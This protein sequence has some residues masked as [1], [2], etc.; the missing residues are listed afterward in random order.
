[1]ALPGRRPGEPGASPPSA[2]R[3]ACAARGPAPRAGRAT[4]TRPGT[5]PRRTPTRAGRATASPARAA[6][7]LTIPAVNPDARFGGRNPSRS[8]IAAIAFGAPP[9]RRAAPPAGARERTMIADSYIPAQPDGSSARGRRPAGPLHPHGDAIIARVDGQ[10]HTV[11]QQP[12]DLPPVRRR[13]SSGPATARR[14]FPGQPTDRS[15]PGRATSR[16]CDRTKRSKSA[17]SRWTACNALLPAAA[18]RSGPPAGSPARTPDTGGQPGPPRTAPAPAAA[19][20]AAGRPAAAARPP[21]PRRARLQGRRLEHLQ[22]LLGQPGLDLG[23]R[24]RLTQRQPVVGSQGTADVGR[25]PIGPPVPHVHPPPA[26]PAPD[27]PGQQA[28]AVADGARAT[29]PGSDWPPAALV[30]LDSLVGDVRRE[31]I[32]QEHQAI[33]GSQPGAPAAPQ[34]LGDLPTR[35]VGRNP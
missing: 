15:R 22:D 35:S 2:S 6:S 20:S 25:P 27:H 28:A 14:H 1:M 16:G 34:A 4:T 31:A 7:A 32:L 17:S 10:H 9:R 29:R 30:R 24:D 26:P 5:G 3:A 13:P 23:R 19:P 12:D 11:H 33:L 18:P 21:P 8:R